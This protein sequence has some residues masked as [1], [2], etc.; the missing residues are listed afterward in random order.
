LRVAAEHATVV[1]VVTRPDRP[2]G[3]GQRLRPTPVKRA[4]LELGLRVYEP[5]TLR[6]WTEAPFSELDLFVLASYGKILPAALLEVPKLGALN[7]HPSLLPLY[8]GATPLQS[9]LRDGASESGV[10]IMLMDDGMDTGD[11]VLQERTPIGA[12]ETYGE[13]HDR[14]AELGAQLLARALASASDGTLVATAQRGTPSITRP[15]TKEDARIEWEWEAERIVNTVRAFSPRP[16]ARAEL[17]GTSAK[18]LRAAL[19]PAAP[20][21]P[22]GTIVGVSG[23]GAVVAAGAGAVNVLSLVP[24]N[25]GTM[26]GAAFATPLLRPK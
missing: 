9:A 23:E 12:D 22:P 1:G 21:A 16:G 5:A 17:H 25:R 19:A 24:E 4:A 18:L 6:G 10:T 26:T 11:I 8:R 20:H 14:L 7:V 3:R 15:L 13:L 2:S